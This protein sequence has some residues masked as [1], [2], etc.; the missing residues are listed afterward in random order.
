TA[1]APTPAEA[2]AEADAALEAGD[3]DRAG[4]L[5]EGVAR[6]APGSAEAAQAR[7]AL[8]ILAVTRAR[9]PSLSPRAA[10]DA[11][12]DTARPASASVGDGSVVEPVTPLV[13]PPGVARAE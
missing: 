4:A 8:R 9:A 12:A 5:Y 10:G 7:R 1:A 3:L 11:A 13:P 6:A 2:L